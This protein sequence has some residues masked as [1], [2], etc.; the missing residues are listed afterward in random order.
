MR[1]ISL[2]FFGAVLLLMMLQQ[3]CSVG[4][5]LT[6]HPVP[7]PQQYL[8]DTLP[9]DSAEMV[10]WW[11]LFNDPVLDSLVR[12]A[13][14]TNR[15]LLV[16]AQRV[17]QAR[18]Q[19]RIAKGEFGPK[20]NA[21]GNMVGGNFF[22]V[23]RSDNFEFF[24]GGANA[25]WE[26]DF[27][28]KFRRLSQNAKANYLSSMSAQRAVQISLIS[29]VTRQYFNLLEYQA[30]LE[31]SEETLE[32]R[33]ATLDIIEARF[34]KGI[35]AEIDLNQSQIQY[36]IAKEAVPIYRQLYYNT[37][38]AL[39]LL[40]GQNPGP[41]EPGLELEQIALQDSIP[42]GLP[43]QIIEKRPDVQQAWYDAVAQNALVGAA[44][45][46]RFPAITL[47]GMVGGAGSDFSN[48][49]SAALAY[50]V[51]GGLV[52]PLF[53]WNQNLRRV[54]FEKAGTEAALF[55]YENSVL[56]ALS[57]VET[58]LVNI[59]ANED[60][61][62]ANLERTEAAVNALYLSDQRY[63]R[64]VTSYLEYLESQRQAFDAQLALATSRAD[65]LRSY[66]DLYRAIGGGW[67]SEEEQQ[68]FEE[69]QEE[70]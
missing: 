1:S 48:F 27:W 16:A 13:L 61:I 38:L 43:A 66:M 14:D 42:P 64:G 39:R 62:E 69:E 20:I 33:R 21:V 11:N 67:I 24:F 26:I 12:L 18:L 31:I 70:D 7:L 49:G 55:N 9:P 47:S 35:A 44:Q 3:S 23:P 22:N 10:S 2:A 58:A 41:V 37:M 4:P 30:S 36:A 32:L 6:E 19:T 68:Q 29:E 59:Q 46:N 17:E 52:A 25:S 8:N 56:T 15:N 50:N 40:T 60:R 28:G 54:Q 63:I 57:E 53:H 65:L 5:N 34:D 51:G 45:A